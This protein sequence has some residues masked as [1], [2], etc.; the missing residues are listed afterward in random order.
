M[1]KEQALA[2]L[3]YNSKVIHQ[4]IN[5]ET[6]PNEVEALDMAIKALEQQPSE[7][8]ITI[9]MDKGTLKY[10]GH[11]YVAYKKDWFRKHFA[12]EVKIMTGYDGYI[13]QPTS[14]DCVCRQ[15]VEQIYIVIN[16]RINADGINSGYCINPSYC[17]DSVWTSK[18][19]AQKR[20]DELNAKLE[21]KPIYGIGLYLVEQKFVRTY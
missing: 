2:I 3:K 7:D 20:C 19:K 18:R 14:D 8:K 15:A 1:T 13:E 4:T 21:E 5:G 12:T 10:S 17:I 16:A 6:D 9:T 11:G